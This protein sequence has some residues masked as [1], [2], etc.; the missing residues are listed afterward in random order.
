MRSGD[1]FR[2]P[3][4]EPSSKLIRPAKCEVPLFRSEGAGGLRGVASPHLRQQFIPTIQLPKITNPKRARAFCPV[5]PDRSDLKNYLCILELIQGA[6]LRGEFD[7]PW[8]AYPP[9]RHN[10]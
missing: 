1:G 4:Q 3:G 10:L 2:R 6:T 9:A 5:L 8:A 7:R